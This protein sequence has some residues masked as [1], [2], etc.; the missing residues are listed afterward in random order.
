MRFL[1]SLR[2]FY[3]F[4]FFRSSCLFPILLF[5]SILSPVS[6]AVA[7]EPPRVVTEALKRAGIARESVGI[8]VQEATPK[9]KLLVASNINTGF[10]PASVMKL[11]TTDAALELLGPS[12]RWKTQAY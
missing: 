12:F 10:N 6:Y 1:L 11:I 8:Y 4:R 9:G 2:A 3:F 5:V 7:Q